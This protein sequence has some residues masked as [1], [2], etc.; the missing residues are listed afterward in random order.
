MDKL[1][2]K[3]NALFWDI[4]VQNFNPVDYPYYTIIR[5]LEFGDEDAFAWLKA[6]FSEEQ[7]KCVIK[8]KKHLSQRSSNF[9]AIVYGIPAGEIASL[10]NKVFAI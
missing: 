4:N 5:I 8:S 1:P 3:L 6:S 10:T 9:W 7:I 2:E